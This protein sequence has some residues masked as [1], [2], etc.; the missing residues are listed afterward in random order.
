MNK[1]LIHRYACY[2][3]QDIQS[4]AAYNNPTHPM[5]IVFAHDGDND[6]GGGYTYYTQC[7][8]SFVQQAISQG[9]NPTTVQQYLT[10]YPVD[11]SDIVHIED[12][13]WINADGD[14]GA[15]RFINWNWPLTG[16]GSAPDFDIPDGWQVNERNWAVITAA[17]NVVETAEKVAG[18]V[19][20]TEIQQPSTF[21]TDAEKAWHFFLPSMTSG[22]M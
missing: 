14:F 22:Y 17:E 8:S 10:D 21:S 18:G 11:E 5:L 2:G 20:I 4:I 9:Y 16:N 19:R 12:G 6:F 13:A 7:V 3:T 15:P 1:L